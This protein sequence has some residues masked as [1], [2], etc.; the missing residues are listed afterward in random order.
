MN[1][2]LRCLQTPLRWGVLLLLVLPGWTAGQDATLPAKRPPNLV[3]F[4]VDDMGWQDT[5]VP[6]HTERTP[7]NQRYQTPN[8]EALAADGVT[9]TQ[10]YAT[11]VCSPTRISLMT[12]QNAARHRV[13]NWTLRRNQSTDARHPTLDF[14]SW[15]VN[16]LSA[17]PETPRAVHAPSLPM[18]LRDGGYHTIHIGKAHFGAIDTPGED[19]LNLGFDVN[20]AGHAAGAPGSFLG[21]QNFSAAW[22]KGDRVWDV[23]H[24]EKYHGKEVFLTEALTIEAKRTIDDAVKKEQPFF[25]YLSHYA[26]HVPFARDP[27]FYDKAIETAYGKR[28]AMYAAMIAGMDHSLGE[29]RTHLAKHDRTDDTVILLVSDNGGLS[30]HGRDGKAH[31]H[32]RPLS[33]GKGSAHEGGTRV[34]LIVSWPGVT[35]SGTRCTAPVIVEDLFATLLEIGRTPLPTE[36]N[37]DGQS[38]VPLL[39][40]E[41]Q[42][43]RESRPL[44]WHYPH[45]WGPRGPG[46]GATSAM[47]LGDWKL[48]YRH[49]DQQYEL[50]DLAQDLE[51]R[52]NLASARPK[53]R[54]R[55]AGKLGR[56][57]AAVK[58]QM[59]IVRET[60]K[61]VP[62][63]GSKPT[64]GDR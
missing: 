33:S 62:Y 46:I 27:R 14:P 59:P 54:D 43:G 40:G 5:S 1:E 36:A 50:Y 21:T 55:L 47:R 30:A 10:G 34:P 18:L 29:I 16:G 20:V 26:V 58:A 35:R 42:P 57:L 8:M 37:I 64:K 53:V 32:N 63:P 44:V 39:R 60:G 61:R 28:E 2:P 25:L 38:V 6:F 22:R 52:N 12:G 4:L 13:T 45:N 56:E 24:L 51:E 7:F 31:T 9:F 19:P 48:I 23:P 49:A 15:N 41:E 11:S 17:D 3:L